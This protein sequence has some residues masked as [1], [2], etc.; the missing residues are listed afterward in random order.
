MVRILLSGMVSFALAVALGKPLIAELKRR[1]LGKNIRADGPASH[2]AKTG[3]P[4]MGGLMILGPVVVLTVT[5]NL[6][7]R[8]S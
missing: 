7:G 8:Q 2:S 5:T 6:A 4:T 3:T 1:G